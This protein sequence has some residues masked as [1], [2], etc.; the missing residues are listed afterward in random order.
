[1]MKL[2]FYLSAVFAFVLTVPAWSLFWTFEEAPVY[3]YT[4]IQTKERIRTS[5]HSAG[6]NMAAQFG[7]KWGPAIHG[8]LFTPIQGVQGIYNPDT[9]NIENK[10]RTDIWSFYNIPFGF[11]VLL[12]AHSPMKSKFSFKMSKDNRMS[13]SSTIGIHL[14]GIFLRHSQYY[15]RRFDS[16]TL[17][18]GADIRAGI[19]ISEGLDMGFLFNFNFDLLDLLHTNNNIGMFYNLNT[20][21]FLRHRF[22]SGTL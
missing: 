14:N 10:S 21:I 2:R 13:F 8:T 11:D 9:N 12:G 1:M 5:F 16:L 4:V 6:I 15:D 7:E 22:G 20:G 3:N 19:Q 18:F 17:G